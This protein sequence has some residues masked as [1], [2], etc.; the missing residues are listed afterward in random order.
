M[1]N[2]RFV[3]WYD[4]AKVCMVCGYRA[5]K[6]GFDYKLHKAWYFCSEQS[7]WDLY[8]LNP[9]AYEDKIEAYAKSM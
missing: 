1:N 8:T 3:R 4:P 7:C 5:S 9:M 2:I 6:R